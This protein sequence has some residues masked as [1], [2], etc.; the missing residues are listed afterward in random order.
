MATFRGD[1]L[2]NTGSKALVSSLIQRNQCRHLCDDSLKRSLRPDT[3]G[4]PIEE[5]QGEM[6]EWVTRLVQ[7]SGWLS[8]ICQILELRPG[9]SPM[10]KSL[11]LLMETVLAF[12][13]ESPSSL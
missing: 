2:L 9:A 4:T 6:A 1:A 8:R 12:K 3:A 11:S 13:I 10:P 7:R 5:R